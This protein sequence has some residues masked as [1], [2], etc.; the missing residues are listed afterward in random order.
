MAEIDE[1]EKL[2]DPMQDTDTISGANKH[3][4]RMYLSMKIPPK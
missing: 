2:H 3:I 4:R 1:K